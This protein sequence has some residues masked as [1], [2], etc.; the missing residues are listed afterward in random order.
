MQKR[1]LVAPDPGLFFGL[2][3]PGRQPHLFNMWKHMKGPWFNKL[4]SQP[5]TLPQTVDIW[6]KAISYTLIKR[7][8]PEAAVAAKKDVKAKVQAVLDSQALVEETC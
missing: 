8:D 7:L 6:R 5:H 4:R 2:D 1:L 3:D